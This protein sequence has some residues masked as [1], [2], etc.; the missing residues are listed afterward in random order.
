MPATKQAV[1]RVNPS[2]SCS[3]PELGDSGRVVFEREG[4]EKNVQEGVNR[5]RQGAIIIA[6]GPCIRSRLHKLG[7]D[8]VNLNQMQA[9]WRETLKDVSRML[10]PEWEL[11]KVDELAFGDHVCD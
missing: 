2:H 4:K 5:T 1:L 3:D 9:T 10:N 7:T 6:T 8:D 11:D